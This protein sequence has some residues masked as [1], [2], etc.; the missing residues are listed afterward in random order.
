MNL[1][2]RQ[3]AVALAEARLSD[4]SQ[5]LRRSWSGLQQEGHAALTPGRVVV[6]GLLSGFFSG[7]ITG[8]GTAQASDGPRQDGEGV[9][10]IVDLLRI[11]GSLLP[12]LLPSLAPAFRAGAAAGSGAAPTHATVTEPSAST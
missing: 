5:K 8:R 7:A 3:Q 12:L 4:A 6:A 1:S 9:S 10:L 2:Q 11:G